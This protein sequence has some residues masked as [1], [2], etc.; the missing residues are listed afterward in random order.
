MAFENL[1]ESNAS[2]DKDF[3][4][5]RPKFQGVAYRLSRSSITGN[6]GLYHL[7]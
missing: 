6:L 3:N 5:A 2:T 4:Q 1:P 7:G